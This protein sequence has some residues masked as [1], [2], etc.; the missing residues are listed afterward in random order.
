MSFPAP[1]VAAG[2][3][4]MP[5]DG[6][7]LRKA[8][9]IFVTDQR[10]GRLW[11]VRGLQIESR[12]ERA[13]AF[14]DDEIADH[15]MVQMGLEKEVHE[16]LVSGALILEGRR[17]GQFQLERAPPSWIRDAKLN[18]DENS[19]ATSDLT[20][21]DVRVT[22]GVATEARQPAQP[23]PVSN[24]VGRP[25]VGAT[26]VQLFQARRDKGVPLAKSQLAEAQAIVAEWPSD[27]RR[28][29]QA[30][31]VS[32]K[33]SEVWQAAADKLRSKL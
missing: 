27:G 11:F 31:T 30:K 15:V 1:P 29:P 28:P 18:V 32:Q 17:P 20:L 25:P 3:N 6:V 24:G 16:Q 21:R 12:S 10:R 33:F 23:A 2:N 26:T 4:A 14:D 13:L 7:P 5:D 22:C 8:L 9:Q 19:I